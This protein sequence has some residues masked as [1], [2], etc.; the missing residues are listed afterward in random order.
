MVCWSVE[1][2]GDPNSSTWD[3][4][5]LQQCWIQYDGRGTGK[6]DF[7]F[8]LGEEKTISL[9]HPAKL[10]H[11]GDKAKL[12]SSND[13]SGFTFL[14]RFTDPSGLQSASVSFEVT[15]KAHNA[16]R[17][18]ISRQGFRNGDQVFVSW[19]VSGK[20]TP[21]PL[22]NTWELFLVDPEFQEE[23]MGVHEASSINHAIDL[24]SSFAV[25]LKKYLAGYHANLDV[26]E[27]ILVMGLDSATPGRMGII[28]YRELLASEFLERIE[29]WHK[30]FAWPQRLTLEFPDPTGKKKMI[31][32]TIWPVSSPAPRAIAEAAYGHILKSND[33]LKKSVVERILPC[34]VDAR[35]FPRDLVD[36]AVKRA[37]NRGNCELWEWQRNLGVACALYK[38]FDL[39]QPHENERR[40]YRMT[41]EEERTTRDY[42][43][44]RLLAIAERIEET[45]L[46]IGGEERPTTAA[47]LMQRF[48]ERPF[49]TWR[50]IE[51][52]LQPYMQRLQAQRTGFLVNRKKEIDKILCAFIPDDFTSEKALSGEFLLG[53]HCQRYAW[54]NKADENSDEKG[55]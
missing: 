49:S 47:R 5:G 36:S 6:R 54:V 28:F 22:K 14:G 30:D 33:V 31:R 21:E 37:S 19:A 52:S 34:I 44:G 3:D 4:T 50:N 38:G 25:K 17:W 48:A 27:Q 35:P 1:E 13:S 39:R 24:G 40:R 43:Y 11:T 45:A 23:V 41:L 29:T 18:L 55:E 20:E 2:S 51:L 53:Y 7:C 12:V 15:Q 46:R 9:N 32:K 16:L 8:V 10:R 42:L 26:N